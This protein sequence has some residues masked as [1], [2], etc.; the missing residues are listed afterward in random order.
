MHWLNREMTGQNCAIS[1]SF[2]SKSGTASVTF[3]HTDSKKM[4]TYV[5]AARFSNESITLRYGRVVI[6]LLAPSP[7]ILKL[8]VYEKPRVFRGHATMAVKL[9]GQ[10]KSTRGHLCVAARRKIKGLRKA[11]E[12]SAAVQP[13]S[14]N[15]TDRHLFQA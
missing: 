12:P 1:K 13:G 10:V 2:R 11:M 9:N 15:V 8:N 7:Y 5:A 3:Q 6:Q 14:M 4:Q